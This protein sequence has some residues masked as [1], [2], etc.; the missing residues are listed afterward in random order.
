MKPDAA[1]VMSCTR[2]AVDLLAQAAAAPR[3]EQVGHVA[4]LEV[5]LDRGLERLVLHH[6]DVDL[7]VRVLGRV[8]VGHRLPV[9]LARIVV[10]DVPPVDRDGLAVAGGL[11]RGR[12]C[13]SVPAVRR[14]LGG[15]RRRVVVAA[16]GG[17]DEAE[18][19]DERERPASP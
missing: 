13:R 4:G 8:G 7:H 2:P 19:G 10:L 6:G 16:A 14:W 5:G 1:S 11:G 3:L 15:V 9:G 17:G 18:R 12:W